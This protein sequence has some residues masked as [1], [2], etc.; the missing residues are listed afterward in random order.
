M[1]VG[2]IKAK[3][4]LYLLVFSDCTVFFLWLEGGNWFY[5]FM[6]LVVEVLTE[7]V[8]T[9]MGIVKSSM[10]ISLNLFYAMQV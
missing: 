2:K 9:D 7:F 6:A 10:I 1:L 3:N 8:L 5:T 4:I